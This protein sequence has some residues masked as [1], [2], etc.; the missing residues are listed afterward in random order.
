MNLWCCAVSVESQHCGWHHAMLFCLAK[1]ATFVNANVDLRTYDMVRCCSQCYR[2]SVS[3]CSGTFELVIK[4]VG[5]CPSC[6]AA[7]WLKLSQ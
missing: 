3:S 5:L 2:M 4:P 6:N 7:A 1:S